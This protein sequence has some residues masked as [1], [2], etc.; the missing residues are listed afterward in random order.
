MF[1]FHARVL[2]DASN[3]PNASTAYNLSGTAETG[4]RS[5]AS[6]M[7]TL[8]DCVVLAEQVDGDGNPGGAWEIAECTYTDAAP[9]TLTRDKLLDS[10]TGSLIDWSG[11]SVPRLSIVDR[12]G[13]MQRV[14]DKYSHDETG[15][16]TS[17][18]FVWTPQTDMSYRLVGSGLNTDHDSSVA[19][20]YLSG[21]VGGSWLETNDASYQMM[22]RSTASYVTLKG[23]AT[24]FI[25]LSPHA[26]MFGTANANYEV[27]ED[28]CGFDLVVSGASRTDEYTH[29]LGTCHSGYSNVA[30]YASVAVIQADIMSVGALQGLRISGSGTNISAGNIWLIE[31]AAYS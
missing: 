23:V 10:S 6:V 22:G 21:R 5:F 8:F 27:A 9:D 3:Q 7:T 25:R 29:F 19:R 28:L 24:T 11:I 2:E 20:I 14:L 18:D 17:V 13:G 15:D 4:H 26:S 31:E 12:P 16:V 30:N 1:Q